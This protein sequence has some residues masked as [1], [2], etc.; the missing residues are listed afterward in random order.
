MTGV[1]MNKLIDDVLKDVKQFY[2]RLGSGL[3]ASPARV[4][5]LEGKL[6]LLLQGGY[7]EFK[8]I[9]D[10][11]DQQLQ[12]WEL[13]LKS[14]YLVQHWQWCEESKTLRLPIKQGDAP[15]YPST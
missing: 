6:S 11:V 13:E 2:K 7:L 9:R 15:V 4:Y 1:D 8:F 5:R 14:D 3:D 10:L 12:N